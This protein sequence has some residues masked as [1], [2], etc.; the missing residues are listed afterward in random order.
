MEQRL[1]DYMVMDGPETTASLG[2]FFMHLPA[3]ALVLEW[4]HEGR[5]FGATQALAP[6]PQPTLWDATWLEVSLE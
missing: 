6:T 2:F 5:H 1:H 3:V 4:G